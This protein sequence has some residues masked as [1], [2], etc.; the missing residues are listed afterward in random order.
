MVVLNVL[1]YIGIIGERVGPEHSRCKNGC[2]QVSQV[3]I[4][5]IS[6]YL[7]PEY[8]GLVQVLTGCSSYINIRVEVYTVCDLSPDGV[9]IQIPGSIKIRVVEVAGHVVFPASVPLIRHRVGESAGNE[10]GITTKEHMIQSVLC[11]VVYDEV[12]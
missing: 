5:F 3:S 1:L 9:T 12:S 2:I 10:V 11:P 7:V 8:P 4:S 6:F